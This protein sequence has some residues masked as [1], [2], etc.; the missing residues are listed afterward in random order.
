MHRNIANTVAPS[1]LSLLAAIKYS[2]A[3]LK[4]DHV[5]LYG[6]SACGGAVAALGDDLVDDGGILD[7]W[8][9]TLKN[10]RA[11]NQEE[12][13]GIKDAGAR[14]VRFAEMNVA[15]GVKVLMANPVIQKAMNERG[16]QVHGT[17]FDIACGCLRDLG[18]GTAKPSKAGARKANGAA[19]AAPEEIIRGQHATLVFGTDGAD[20]TVR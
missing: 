14:A 2:V 13:N 1:D 3:V 4:V 5:I 7:T 9:S 20:M 8:L 16:L 18:V 17:L 12:L 11:A 19:A 10:I 6:H 15:A